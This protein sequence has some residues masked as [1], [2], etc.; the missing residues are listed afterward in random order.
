MKFTILAV[1]LNLSTKKCWVKWDN[2]Y[3]VCAKFEGKSPSIWGILSPVILRR[4]K[5]CWCPKLRDGLMVP[6]LKVNMY[7][8]KQMVLRIQLVGKIKKFWNLRFLK[9]LILARRTTMIKRTIFAIL[10]VHFLSCSRIKS[11]PVDNERSVCDY[12][13]WSLSVALY[14]SNVGTSNNTRQ[15]MYVWRKI[16]A[17]LW[18]ILS[19]KKQ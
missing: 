10:C 7:L 16:E 14:F 9:T 13:Y 17:S 5:G 15:A 6:F 8:F 2:R 11:L 19:V 3:A 4:I 12:M 18:T 1:F